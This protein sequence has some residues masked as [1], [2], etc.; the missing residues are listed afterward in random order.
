MSSFVA[1]LTDSE[2]AAIDKPGIFTCII[3][4]HNVLVNL[5]QTNPAFNIIKLSLVS[6]TSINYEAAIAGLAQ[7]DVVLRRKLILVGMNFGTK[8]GPYRLP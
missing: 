8:V 5:L 7:R 3:G 1:L 2:A 6:A 4:C